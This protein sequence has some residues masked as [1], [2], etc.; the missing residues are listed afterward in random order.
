MKN[1]LF[2]F[3]GLALLLVIIDQAIKIWVHKNMQL[4]YYGQ[5]PILGDFFS[6]F[7]TLND[8]VAFGAFS[9]VEGDPNRVDYFKSILTLVRLGASVA[10]AIY[11]YKSI[12]KQAKAGFLWALAFILGGAVGNII[13]CMFY[14]VIPS[15]DNA[16]PNKPF[17]FLNGQVI[18]MFYIHICDIDFMG[19][20]MTLW[21]IFNF[22][23]ACIFCAVIFVIIK[24]KSFLKENFE[25]LTENNTILEKEESVN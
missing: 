11:L 2:K 4:G 1:K 7:Y 14:G 24:N 22:A 10:I 8:G 18:D 21:P 6:L 20:Q 15:I 23:D 13:D 5:I 25:V 19:F 17:K 16:L 3:F 12:L 9:G